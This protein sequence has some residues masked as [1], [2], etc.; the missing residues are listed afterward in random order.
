MVT[1]PSKILHYCPTCKQDR[2]FEL[3]DFDETISKYSCTYCGRIIVLYV[4][5]A[6]RFEAK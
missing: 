2:L 6:I 4:Q 5:D 1:L 3:I